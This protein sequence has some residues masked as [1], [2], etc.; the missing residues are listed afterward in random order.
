MKKIN[1]EKMSTISGGKFFG[2]AKSCGKC[3]YGTQMCTEK[4]YFFWIPFSKDA[5]LEP[6]YD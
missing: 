5:G 4:F 1:E 2:S 6:C 3:V